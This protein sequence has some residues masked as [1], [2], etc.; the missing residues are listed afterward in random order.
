MSPCHPNEKD[1]KSYGLGRGLK[2]NR[3]DLECTD[4]CDC[5]EF[6]MP[7]AKKINDL[8]LKHTEAPTAQVPSVDFNSAQ[9]SNGAQNRQNQQQLDAFKQAYPFPPDSPYYSSNKLLRDLYLSRVTRNP[10]LTHFPT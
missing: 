3:A 5:E 2:R 10:E 7:L 4:S 8:Q 1:A 9:S 6:G